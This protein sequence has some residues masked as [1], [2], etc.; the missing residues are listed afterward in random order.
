MSTQP[1][2]AISANPKKDIKDFAVFT[3]EDF[4]PDI[5]LN[6]P[7]RPEHFSIL[8]FQKGG[9][10]LLHNLVEYNLEE[11]ELVLLPPKSFY[12]IQSFLPESKMTI[13][14]FNE[15]FFIE[16][17]FHLNIGMVIDLLKADIRKSFVLAKDDMDTLVCLFN[18][19]R[20][21][22][23]LQ[24]QNQADQKIIIHC[25]S[26]IIYE[27]SSLLTKNNTLYK[28]KLNRKEELALR[29]LQLVAQH[30]EE[31]RSVGYFA[32]QLHVTPKHL[33]ETIKE[34]TGKTAGKLIDQAVITQAKVLLR[35]PAMNIG[36]VATALHFSDQSFFGKFF[37]KHVGLSPIKYRLEL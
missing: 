18:L 5:S 30:F 32:E 10:K 28:A 31:E 37:K 8:L 22:Q 7:Y 4:L 13:M 2:N 15:S 33:S 9:M 24:E 6:T 36:E 19:L 34:V 25:F 1:D 3:E 21:K 35:N 14:L 29:F 26:T 17:G 11:N 16:A 12:Q 20:K 23:L 27:C